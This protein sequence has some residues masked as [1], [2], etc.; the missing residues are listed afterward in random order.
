M[1]ITINGRKVEAG[2]MTILELAKREGIEIPTLC[3]HEE[4]GPERRCRMCVVE[5]NGKMMSSC[6]TKLKDGMIIVTDSEKVRKFR[7]ITKR[8]MELR[9]K[10]MKKENIDEPIVYDV[11]K[12]ILCTSCA[13]VCEKIQNVNSIDEANRG[14]KTKIANPFD[15]DALNSPCT[16][17][18]QCIFF[19]PNDAI[20]ERNDIEKVLKALVDKKKHV[21][22]QTAPSIRASIGELFGMP[23]QLVTGNLAAALRKLGFKKV[24][25]TNFGADITTFEE[26]NEFIERL[27]KKKLPHIT[28]C[29]PAW[30]RLAEYYYPELI[31]KISTTKS[32]HMMLGALA[33]TYYAEK[34]GINPRDIIVVSVMPCTAK[35]FEIERPQTKINGM[36]SVDIVITTRELGE[37]LKLKGIDLKKMKEEEFDNP[38][39]ISSGGAAIYGVTG[40]VTENVLRSA[41]YILGEKHGKIEFSEVRGFE[42]IK[43][44]SIKLG[45][46]EIRIAVAN[47][48]GNVRKL[49]EMVKK[50]GKYDVIEIMACPGGCI[51]GGG[52]PKSSDKDI[53]RKRAA[54]LFAQ[55]KKLPF[56]VANENP[57]L[58]EVYKYLGK[59]LNKK[60]KKIIHTS[61]MKRE[62]I[63]KK[64]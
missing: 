19:C 58:K 9:E 39:G 52:Q 51:G 49:L 8:L 54:A 56:R 32:P 33:K 44:A 11:S 62:I 43:E 10:R 6:D 34:N 50:G 63:L 18:G 4:F 47:G 5:V 27:E 1:N 57:G 46:K 22:V 3:Y 59:P 37:L 14:I 17:C 21:I 55:D 41:L 29:C 12:C 31:E 2:D 25:D 26:T 40:G 13:K 16:F 20:F 42:G 35:K 60:S 7:N 23:G 64:K 30:I 28:S 45:G 61:Y 38:L 48:L 15:Y 24:F 36:K 53:V